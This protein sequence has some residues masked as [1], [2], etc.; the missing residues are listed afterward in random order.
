MGVNTV[1]LQAD[2]Q[3]GGHVD[4]GLLLYKVENNKKHRTIKEC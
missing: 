2:T 1:L 4:W 3:G